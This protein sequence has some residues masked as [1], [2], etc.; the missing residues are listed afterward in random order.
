[1]RVVDCPTVRCAST[2]GLPSWTRVGPKA[3]S[4][5]SIGIKAVDLDQ[6]FVD[7]RTDQW[8]VHGTW[9]ET[10]SASQA[11]LATLSGTSWRDRPVQERRVR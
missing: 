6:R 7:K 4:R 8:G 11:C 10:G 2:E 3:P 1:M 5:S 9:M